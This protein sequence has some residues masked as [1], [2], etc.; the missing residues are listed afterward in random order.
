MG[1]LLCGSKNG[2]ETNGG[3]M[4]LKVGQGQRW[5]GGG[6]RN[7]SEWCEPVSSVSS[8]RVVQSLLHGPRKFCI[9]EALCE[10]L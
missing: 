3:G 2:T 10:H 8:R 1:K 4:I 9:H 6:N 5:G 7:T